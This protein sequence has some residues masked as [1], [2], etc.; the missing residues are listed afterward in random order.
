MADMGAATML[1]EQKRIAEMN[2]G[3]TS[4]PTDEASEVVATGRQ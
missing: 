4:T 1:Q 2:Q 3:H